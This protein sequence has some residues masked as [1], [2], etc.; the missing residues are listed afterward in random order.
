MFRKKN[1]ASQHSLERL[2]TPSE[3]SL[4]KRKWIS[5]N[6][7]KDK[8][9]QGSDLCAELS[10][11]KSDNEFL[12]MCKR[13]SEGK[14]ED[15]QQKIANSDKFMN[16]ANKQLEMMTGR[17]RGCLDSLNKAHPTRN[18]EKDSHWN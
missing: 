18:I 11:A 13:S 14:I 2:K 5:K 7:G 3:L 6:K 4:G 1:K 17:M 9:S 16:D 15:L 12:L 10:R 8:K